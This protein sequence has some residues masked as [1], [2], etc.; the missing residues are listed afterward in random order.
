MRLGQPISYASSS[1]EASQS[2]SRHES[3]KKPA[4]NRFGEG[5]ILCVKKSDVRASL[6]EKSETSPLSIQMQNSGEQTQVKTNQ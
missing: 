3:P 2:N 4:S 5:A 1:A 6:E